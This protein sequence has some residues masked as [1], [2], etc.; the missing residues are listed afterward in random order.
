MYGCNDGTEGWAKAP[1]A[2]PFLKL[3]SIQLFLKN[4]SAKLEISG[5][6]DENESKII[7]LAS[8]HYIKFSEE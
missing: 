1:D 7:S 3:A 5:W 8:D 4:N 2:L 6:K